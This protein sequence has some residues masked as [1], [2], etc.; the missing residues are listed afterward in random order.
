MLMTHVIDLRKGFANVDDE[1]PRRSPGIRE[2]L[3]TIVIDV[4]KELADVD[5]ERHGRSP[6]RREH[7]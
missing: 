6:G 1:R 5:D 7:G 2:M 3:M 4:R